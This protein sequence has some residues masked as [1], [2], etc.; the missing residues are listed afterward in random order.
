VIV[1]VDLEQLAELAFAEA[2]RHPARSAERRAAGH[3]W[4]ALT[5]PA[6]G[7]LDAA[8]RAI[9]SFGTPRN[10]AAAL[11]LLHKLAAQTSAATAADAP[12]ERKPA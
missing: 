2:Q 9:A 3:L 8:R 6:A 4:I 5:I 11:E 10:Q 12:T 7:S 1:A